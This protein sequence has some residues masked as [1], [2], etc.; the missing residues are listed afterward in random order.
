MHLQLV[1]FI[2]LAAHTTH[3]EYLYVSPETSGV[4]LD[5]RSSLAIGVTETEYKLIL[6]QCLI[7]RDIGD[8]AV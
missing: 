5:G 7:A 4:P 1:D 3:T 6:H 2:H 8:K